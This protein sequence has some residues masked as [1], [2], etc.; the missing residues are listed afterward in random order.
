MSEIAISLTNVSKC[1]KRYDRPLDRLKE[2]VLPGKSRAQEFWALRDINL[3]VAP[4]ETLGIVG[5]NGSGKSTLLQIIAGTLTPTT[6]EVWV[7]GR[8]SALLELGSGFNP[9]FTG[10][11]NVFFNGQILGL[12]REE[13]A[14]KFDSI[15]AFADIGD[16]LDQPVK[17]YSSGM[18]VRLA[19]AVVANIDPTILIIDE[20]L[21]VGDAR[22]QARCMKR[23]RQ[24][25]EQ[26]VT[27]L[28]VS[29][30]SASIKMLCTRAA[31]INYGSIIEVGQ[32]KRVIDHY[33]AL[34]SSDKSCNHQ[35]II[36]PRE[37]LEFNHCQPE[38]SSNR[39]LPELHEYRHGT[40]IAVINEVNITNSYNRKVETI[41]TGSRFNIQ[42]KL[43][44]NANLSDLV[45]G[46][47]IRNLMGLVMYGTNTQ[48]LNCQ[49]P[50]LDRGQELSV[51]FQI[52]CNLHKGIYTVTIGVHSQEGLSY[53]WIDDLVV[54]EVINGNHCEGVVDLQ[55]EVKVKPE[56]VFCLT[57]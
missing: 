55:A 57:P 30:D 42:V 38:T 24:L 46:I 31:L 35:Q 48:L 12:S 1:Y 52:P 15:A 14:A 32:P 43:A 53:D 13:I 16:F 34:L 44:V 20:A 37:R 10:R 2:I 4:G 23:I 3:E 41:E 51:G 45:I 11:Q 26:G 54:F 25:K 8:V 22:F 49:L 17:T 19:F 56:A 50:Q 27:I 28:F 6:G 21:A 40:R 5:Q 33:T 7:N 29:H 9:E 47:S 36:S 18:V 39:T